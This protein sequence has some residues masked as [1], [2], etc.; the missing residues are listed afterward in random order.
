MWE[1]SKVR[2]LKPVTRGA[3]RKAYNCGDLTRFGR[4][5]TRENLGELFSVKNNP[6]GSDLTP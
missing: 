4:P 2:K 1:E 6:R 5:V 3:V